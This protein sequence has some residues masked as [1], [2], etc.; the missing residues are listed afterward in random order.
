[1][2]TLVS[3]PGILVIVPL[4]LIFFHVLKNGAN[5]LSW[6]FLLELPKPVGEVGGGMF[7]AIL[8]TI[9]ILIIGGFI[10]VIWG[11]GAGVYLSEYGRGRFASLLRF[12]TDLLSGT[13][14]IVIGLFAYALLVV[15]LKG[16]SALAGGVAL[17]TII[18]PTVIRTTEEVLKLVPKDIR[19]AGLALGLPRFVV[20]LKIV[21]YGS[22]SGLLTG[23][24][25]SLSRASGETAPLL[26]TAFGNMYLSFDPMAPMAALP[27][28]IYNYAISPFEDWQRQAWAGAFILM[29]LVF[30]FNVL[31]KIFTHFDT[32]K[33]SLK[34]VLYE[35]KV[36]DR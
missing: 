19:E 2:L 4:V 27:L 6:N 36:K 10:G 1:M 14:S 17:S 18:L 23:I 26:F 11:L 13:P 32:L 34:K 22:R 8:G 30:L 7:H 29:M 15:P 25:L 33:Y 31:A 21:V 5:A 20:I 35:R 24:L 12:T 16:F 9:Y 3:L 28:Q